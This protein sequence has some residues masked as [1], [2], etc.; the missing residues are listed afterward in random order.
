M[1]NPTELPINDEA[2]MCPAAGLNTEALIARC[3]A[4]QVCGCI[5]ANPGLPHP[6]K[7]R[8]TSDA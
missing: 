7:K 1:L 3:A 4:A 8:E 5:S 6:K 2:R